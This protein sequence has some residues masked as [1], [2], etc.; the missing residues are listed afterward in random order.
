MRDESLHILQHALGLD[1]YGR[2]SKGRFPASVEEPYRNRYVVGPDS[3]A[4]ALCMEHVEAGR[5]T[6]HDECRSWTGG[7][8]CF[9]VTA[10]GLAFVREHSPRP[11]K[12]TR[13]QQRYEEYLDADS[14]LS[15][16]EW[17]KARS[18]DSREKREATG[19]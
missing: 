7:M 15:F 4:W 10:A 1:E 9:C 2:D 16:G 14:S 5:M 18:R 8:S 17:L 12:R 19:A 11:P 3:D 6:R 13:A